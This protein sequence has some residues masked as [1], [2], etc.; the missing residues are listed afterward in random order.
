MQETRRKTLTGISATFGKLL[1]GAGKLP[2]RRQTMP[3]DLTRQGGRLSNQREVQQTSRVN[4][5]GQLCQSRPSNSKEPCK[6]PLQTSCLHKWSSLPNGTSVRVAKA[7]EDHRTFI[8]TGQRTTLTYHS[9]QKTTPP[10]S[11]KVFPPMLSDSFRV[12]RISPALIEA[13][14]FRIS[15]TF[16]PCRGLTKVLRGRRG[17]MIAGLRSH[18]SI[19]KPKLEK[20][21]RSRFKGLMRSGKEW[22]SLQTLTSSNF[23]SMLAILRVN[24]RLTS[25]NL[26]MRALTTTQLMLSDS[27]T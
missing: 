5:R 1:F 12:R 23:C 21:P 16:N 13:H 2:R 26:W 25:K 3:T 18:K 7:T 20:K 27:L 10:D 19:K 11:V 4:K 24:L 22:M 9:L 8:K 15:I 14:L 6:W 17:I